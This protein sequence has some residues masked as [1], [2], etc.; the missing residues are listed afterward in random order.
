MAYMENGEIK[1]API[2]DRSASI[3]EGVYRDYVGNNNKPDVIETGKETSQKVKT[4]LQD[5]ASKG[6]DGIHGEALAKKL[7]DMPA[8][9]TEKEAAEYRR[10]AHWDIGKGIVNPAKDFA[11]YSPEERAR[12]DAY[13]NAIAQR[14]DKPL[15]TVTQELAKQEQ[16]A[17]RQETIK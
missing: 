3:S 11:D 8:A 7:A 10:N 16:H 9:M 17:D 13:Q 12:A 2:P 4:E 1:M 15:D 6:V 14:G 5:M